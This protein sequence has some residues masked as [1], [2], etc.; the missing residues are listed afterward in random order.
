M[1]YKIC[2]TKGIVICHLLA[3]YNQVST[4]NIFMKKLYA[5]SL[6]RDLKTIQYWD[7]QA[8]EH[9]CDAMKT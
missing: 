6:C 2:T 8:P 3:H 9:M 1:Y 4:I 5:Q 7:P